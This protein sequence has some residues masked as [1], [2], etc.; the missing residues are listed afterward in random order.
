MILLFLNFFLIKKFNFL[1][2]FQLVIV[3]EGE[4][5][6]ASNY[7]ESTLALYSNRFTR[8]ALSIAPLPGIQALTIE[9]HV[10]PLQPG[11]ISGQFVTCYMNSGAA[12]RWL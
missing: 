11:P 1:S 12:K 2:S 10:H 4:N 3:N 7:V 8:F 6:R 5:N 9:K